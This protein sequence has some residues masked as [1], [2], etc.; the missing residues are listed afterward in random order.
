MSGIGGTGVVTASQVIGTAAMLQGL[1]VRGMDQTGLSQKAGPVV[2]DLRLSVDAPAASNKATLSSLDV[3]LAFDRLVGGADAT[4]RVMDPMRTTVIANAAAVP[5]GGM[6]THPERAFPSGEVDERLGAVSASRLEVDAHRLTTQL[7]GD[8]STVNIFMVGVA[9]QAGH[10]PID[11]ALI[12]QAIELNG[13]AVRKNVASFRWG[14][15]WACEPGAVE[16]T[17][18]PV[19]HTPDAPLVERLAADLEGYQ[20][21][22]YAERF[23]TVVAAVDER[24]FPD[25]TEAV[26]RHLHKLMAYKDEYEAARLL[27]DGAPKGARFML[28]P[29]FLRA[30]GMR[31]KIEL[32]GW[33]RPMLRVLRGMRRLRGTAFDP[34]GRAKVR[35]LERKLVREYLAAVDDIVRLVGADNIDEAIAIASL[36][37]RVRGYEHLKLERVAAYQDE[38][39]A[40][41]AAFVA[42]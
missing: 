26:A 7:L 38:L 8:D 27:L 12:E 1:H 31:E 3:L 4:T 24:G 34:F 11:P 9:V 13:V 16:H 39:A 2:S 33:I 41:L 17:A 15:A 14:R 21:R 20:N 37:D 29:P 25:L 30:M 36:P 5:T 10:L 28:H 42:G 35:R 32:G 23:R 40:R 6:V 18:D 19:A 22:A